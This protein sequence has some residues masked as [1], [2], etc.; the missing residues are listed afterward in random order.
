MFCVFVVQREEKSAP[1]MITDFGDI[2]GFLVFSLLV[3]FLS[4]LGRV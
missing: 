2:W 4:F 3:V 1:K